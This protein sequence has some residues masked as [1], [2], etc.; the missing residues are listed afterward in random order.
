MN[1]ANVLKRAWE[2]LWR[3]RVLW[4]FGVIVA[5]TATSG[6]SGYWGRGGDGD[7]DDWSSCRGIHIYGDKCIPWEEVGEYP[8]GEL[9]LPMVPPE[10]WTTL[11]AIVVGLL[12]L[13]LI[14]G[15]ARVVFLYI[16]ETA[17]IR[18][19]D[20]YEVTGEKRGVRQ[21]FRLG[22]SRT[23]LKLFVIDLLTRLPGMLIAFMLLVLGVGMFGLTVWAGGSWRLIVVGAIAAAGL[24]CLSIPLV[25]VVSLVLSLLRPFFWRVSALEK[26][27]V[28]D[29]IR[30]GCRFVRQ[31]LADAI[32]MWLIMVGLQVGWIIVMIPVVLLLMV[33]GGVLGGLAGLVVGGLAGLA[34]SG[35]VPWILGFAVGIPI[36][37][38]VMAAPLVFLGG[39]A[40]VF[41][42]SVWTLTYR[43]LRALGGSEA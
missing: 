30:E 40:H 38:L 4:V 7:R 12:C 28:I 41:K 20:D 9:P 13:A 16:A 5:L 36:F 11:A 32:I 25:I 14:V 39:L 26:M 2:I 23:A 31:H 29:S 8:W 27:G 24:L 37:I 21:G 15:I 43:E 19:V 3:Y 33:V 6:T 35:A 10:V 1:H 34:W 18:M 22:W 17:L 42:S